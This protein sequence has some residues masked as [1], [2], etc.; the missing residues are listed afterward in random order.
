[1]ADAGRLADLV[2]GASGA[3]LFGLPTPVGRPIGAS[4]TG[5]FPTFTL[6]FTLPLP[7][8]RFEIDI[9]PDH[10][11]LAWRQITAPKVGADD[12]VDDIDLVVALRQS[13]AGA[14]AWS[15]RMK[16][17]R[18]I[19]VIAAREVTRLAAIAAERAAQAE[20]IR[21]APSF[22]PLTAAETEALLGGELLASLNG[23]RVS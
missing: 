20:S 3:I 8:R 12:E 4:T 6:A 14:E 21:A 9:Q 13:L 11:L 17:S 15:C 10:R 18:R 22:R 7:R 5:Y 1:M 19:A 2:I 16:T 23:M